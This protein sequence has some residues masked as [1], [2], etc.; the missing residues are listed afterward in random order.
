MIDFTPQWY[1]KL[2]A[3]RW[4]HGWFEEIIIATL[5]HADNPD[6]PWEICEKNIPRKRYVRYSVMKYGY[7][8]KEPYFVVL[9]L[10]YY[11]KYSILF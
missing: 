6:G 4:W 2:D 9:P 10:P 8:F 1:K 3:D 7:G 11:E 5:Q